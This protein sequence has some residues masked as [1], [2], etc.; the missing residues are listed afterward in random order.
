N[1]DDPGETPIPPATPIAEDQAAHDLA[2]QICA[3]LFDCDCSDA[4]Y[5]DDEAACVEARSA[6]I[7][8]ELDVFLDEGWQWNN[9]CAGELLW[10]WRN[11]ACLGPD[12]ARSA[13]N[14]DTRRCPLFHGT[15]D[16]G[17]FCYFT[18]YGDPCAPGLSCYDEY[19]VDAP[20]LPIPTGSSCG[21]GWE[22]LP[23]EAGS[24]C[25]YEYLDGSNTC[26]P[27]PKAGDGCD[28]GSGTLCGPS[29]LDLICDPE[30]AKCVGAPGE[31]E[32][33]ELGICAPGY[34]C[35]GGLDFT[36]QPRQD[37]GEGCGA[38][39]VCPVD[40]SCI[41]NECV[42]DPPLACELVGW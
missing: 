8:L 18:G 26:T 25:K 2:V 14:F 4:S 42:L 21:N 27:Y 33:C 5:Y 19:C 29:S 10:T 31:G 39:V 35:D 11:W 12:S 24:Y 36:C 22:Q 6:E 38:D 9:E 13:A 15:L 30:T 32:T 34:Y 17:E 16:K 40:A 23:C 20:Q 41:N 28:P 1:S 37:I 3:G 7:Q